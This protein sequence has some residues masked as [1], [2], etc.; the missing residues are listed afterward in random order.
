QRARLVEQCPAKDAVELLAANDTVTAADQPALARG[1]DWRHPG[2][3]P[4]LRV[5]QVLQAHPSPCSATNAKP[6]VLPVLLLPASRNSASR[7]HRSSGWPL[8][9]ASV[10]KMRQESA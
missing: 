10:R 9:P 2:P 7:I 1:G 5:E 4:Q 6:T 3:V 8:T